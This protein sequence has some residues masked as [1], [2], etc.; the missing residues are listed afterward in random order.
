MLA[1]FKPSFR[2]FIACEDQG[3]LFQARKVEDQVQ[4]L[5]GNEAQISRVF[6][7]FSLLRY[8]QLRKHASAEAAEAEMLI[9]AFGENNELPDHVKSLLDS[10]PS[11]AQPGQAALVCLMGY[12][13]DSNVEQPESHLPY[14]REV[15]EKCGLDFF[16]NQDGWDVLDLSK[17]SA[18]PAPEETIFHHVPWKP[19]AQQV[20][21]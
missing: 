8:D 4:S 18:K 11:R 5:C 1:P 12:K 15:A 20:N 7:S 10:L 9:I 3:A 2:L 17:P 16:C 19:V 21:S 6:W 14:L 13:K